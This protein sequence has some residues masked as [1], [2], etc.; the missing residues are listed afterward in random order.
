MFVTRLDFGSKIV[1]NGAITQIDL[2][3]AKV[4]GL[5]EA[6]R[7]LKEIDDIEI[8]RLTDSDVVRHAIVQRIIQAYEKDETRRKPERVDKPERKNPRRDR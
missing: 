3:T 4:S 6:M 7:V 8:C 5:K 2:L 1:L